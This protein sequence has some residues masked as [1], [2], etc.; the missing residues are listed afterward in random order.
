MNIN[1]ELLSRK[2]N[3]QKVHVKVMLLSEPLFCL[4]VLVATQTNMYAAN[5]S[6]KQQHCQINT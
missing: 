5:K 1:S 4:H 3:P 2:L 6:L